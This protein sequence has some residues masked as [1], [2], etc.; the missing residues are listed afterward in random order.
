MITK[1]KILQATLKGPISKENILK[2]CK[3]IN[4]DFRHIDRLDAL[5]RK[6]IQ[7]KKI[8]PVLIAEEIYYECCS[9]PDNSNDN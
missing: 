1:A 3:C 2:Q 7:E 6:L 4:P 8:I 5:I 9:L